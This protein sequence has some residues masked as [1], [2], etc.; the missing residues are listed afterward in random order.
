MVLTVDDVSCHRFVQATPKSLVL[1]FYQADN[2]PE[3]LS[4]IVFGRGRGWM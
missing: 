1:L 3:Y 4:W 2:T